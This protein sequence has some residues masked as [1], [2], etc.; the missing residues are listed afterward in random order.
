MKK[1][2]VIVV[3]VLILLFASC[4][5]EV[6]RG[7]GPISTQN[8]NSVIASNYHTIKVHGATKVYVNFSYDKSF[9]IKGYTNL[10][11]A[12]STE[13]RNGVLML[14]FKENVTV[15][16]DNIQVYIA[17][18]KTGSIALNGNCEAHYIGNFPL[19]DEINATI[20]GNGE[21][22]YQKAYSNRA[23]FTIN[24]SGEIE[25][26]NLS[27]LEA[28]VR[29]N[30]SGT[31]KIAAVDKLKANI[32]GSG[33]IYYLGNPILETNISGSGKIIPLN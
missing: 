1:V 20:N 24:G 2:V 9:E 19:E 23:N 10:L 27:T 7:E 33:N 25:G 15:R 31:A 13:I 26:E 22:S 8:R 30:G 16:N 28:N 32:N 14:G 18:P 6:L 21:I 4:K 3:P 17:Y 11:N 29:I 12:F 5:K